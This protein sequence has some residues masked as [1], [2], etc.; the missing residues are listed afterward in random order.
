MKLKQEKKEYTT[1]E[2]F[3]NFLKKNNDL[4]AIITSIN[5]KNI[6][7]WYN[8]FFKHNDN[9]IDINIL[10]ELEI[11]D[12]KI[13]LS[14]IINNCDT[15][16]G[17]FMMNELLKNPISDLNILNTRKNF[18][19]FFIKNNDISNTITKNLN[20]I[21]L[22]NE[23]LLWFWN[24]INEHSEFIY[25]MVYFESPYL[26][27]L[28]KNQSYLQIINIYKIVISPI[29]SV[30][31]PLIY[32][33]LP[34]IVL[35]YF[36][37]NIPFKFFIKMMWEQNSN[38]INL[39][40]IKNKSIATLLNYFSKGMTVFFYFKN[41]FNSYNHSKNIF[42]LINTFKNKLNQ[43]RKITIFNNFINNNFNIL[44]DKNN[45][46]NILNLIE[47]FSSLQN[48]SKYLDNKGK[49]LSLFYDFLEKKDCLIKILQNIG[50]IDL[51]NNL[52]NL[53]KNNNNNSTKY[54]I[55]QFIHSKNPKISVKNTWHLSLFNK[56]NIVLN[57]LDFDNE[58]NNY[59]LTGP[60]A[61]GKSTFIK[62]ILLNIY[63]AQTLAISNCE[64]IILTPFHYL[65]TSIKNQDEQGKE[66]LFEAE[67]HKIKKHLNILEELKNENKFS[68]SILDEI[69][70]ST[71]YIEGLV[72]S[73]SFCK[74][75]SKFNNSFHIITTHF[76]KL[77]KISNKKKYKF[78][79]IY[80]KINYDNNNN[81]IFPYKLEEG[82]SK[83]YIALRLMKERDMSS[84]FI[85]NSLKLLNKMTNKNKKYIE[86]INN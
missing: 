3:T 33:I 48:K 10:K 17:S 40:F 30:V 13:N 14:K 70:T 66:S 59:L 42:Y 24:D 36:K 47:N 61:A 55:P 64:N 1:D 54:S 80:F 71:N 63:L 18:L 82:S 31:S 78:K 84:N 50:I 37:I 79:N 29:Y 41:I 39:P 69:F 52:A 35:K 53:I 11:T 60:N 62:S 73:Y 49:V 16:Y 58:T 28:N 27:F 57:S 43:I 9:R 38:I 22:F 7:I 20:E 51:F 85:N 8:K 12:D 15:I 5:K 77:S 44:N 32:L 81:I 25:N 34:Y 83:Q 67:M 45:K 23:E 26:N 68:F 56:K 72:S 2:H 19:Q 86:I 4:N 21:K 65:L 76:T 46:E 75:I 74:E 6:P